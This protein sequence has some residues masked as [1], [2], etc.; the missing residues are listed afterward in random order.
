[1]CCVRSACPRA[2][3]VIAG[4]LPHGD[5]RKLEVAHPDRA[6]AAGVSVRRADRRHE[7][8]RGAGH[9][10]PHPRHQATSRDRTILLVEHK[11]DVVRSLADRIVVLHNGELV[12]DGD[13]ATVIALPVVQEAYLGVAECLR[14]APLLTL[15]RRQHPYRALSHPPGRRSRGAARRADHA[16]GPQRRRQDHDAAHHH[17]AVA[18]LRRRRCVSTAPTSPPGRRPTSPRP[19]S[20]TCRRTWASSP[21]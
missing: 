19:A 4:L 17:G 5:Q 12:A 21:T 3:I 1:M 9:P 7:R 14:R 20:P 13:P 15:D 2:A 18:R 11:M 6:R 16:A 10:R 8:R